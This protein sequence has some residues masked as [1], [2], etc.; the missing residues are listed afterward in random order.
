MAGLSCK[1]SRRESIGRKGHA[2]RASLFPVGKDVHIINP[3]TVRRFGPSGNAWARQGPIAKSDVRARTPSPTQSRKRRASRR[4]QSRMRAVPRYRSSF[5]LSFFPSQ[6]RNP[7]LSAG[8]IRDCGQEWRSLQFGHLRR[9]SP[10]RAVHVKA[11]IDYGFQSLTFETSLLTLAPVRPLQ[12][13][14]YERIETW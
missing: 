13:P 11:P 8:S 4:D 12:E 2:L 3:F 1:F 9:S 10:I 5:L 7:A 14:N 6:N